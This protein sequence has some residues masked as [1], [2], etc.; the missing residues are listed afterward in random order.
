MKSS[1]IKEPK[2]RINAPK[3]KDKVKEGVNCNLTQMLYLNNYTI[4]H[5]QNEKTERNIRESKTI[6][7]IKKYLFVKNQ[8]D[9]LE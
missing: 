1:F 5:E 3:K 7:F 6:K 2:G 4:L 8:K 9:C